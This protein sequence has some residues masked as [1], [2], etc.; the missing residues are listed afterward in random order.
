MELLYCVECGEIAVIPVT[1]RVDLD[2][3]KEIVPM[4]IGQCINCMSAYSVFRRGG[5]AIVPWGVRPSVYIFDHL[6][7]N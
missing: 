6:R 4:I 5:A 2:T 7:A 3:S 1:V